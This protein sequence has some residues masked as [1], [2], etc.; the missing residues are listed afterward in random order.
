MNIHM[1]R[2]ILSVI[3]LV[4]LGQPSLLSAQ[5]DK[6]KTDWSVAIVEAT[7]KRLPTPKDMGV[8]N[9][10]R[11]LYLYS[12]YLVYKR[13]RD[14]RYL[15]Y[16]KDWV[17][18]HVDENGVITN[19]NPRGEK[20]E[21]RF[22]SLDNMMPGNLL[23]A[24]YQETKDN[25]YKL[26]AERIRIRFSGY[27]RTTD[28]GFWHAAYRTRESQLW[29][30]G[31]FMSMP[32]LIRYGSIFGDEK[33][34]DNEAAKQL[35]VY[36]SHLN[37]PKTGLMFH[38]YDE[39]GKATWTDKQTKHSPEIWCRAMGWF[40]MTIVEVLELIPKDHPSRPKLI[41]QLNQLIKA[42]SNFQ[43]KKTGLWYQVVDKGSD[44]ANWLE[45]SSSSMY[46]FTIARAV[47]RGYVDKSYLKVAKLGYAG[48]LT[49][50]SI[51][52]DGGPNLIDICE[53]TNVADLPY[54]FARKRLTNDLHGLGAFLIMNEKF[55]NHSLKGSTRSF[56][57]RG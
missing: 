20:V 24:M 3:L 23:L 17:D 25:R 36:A 28:G 2:F 40:G 4:L 5:T 39:S 49:K 45:T 29:G 38:A 22:D 53:G 43:D 55:M 16:I 19:I 42:W 48:V 12:Q 57:K 7:M 34:A 21:V 31:V 11:G 50:I 14:P 13:T 35:L 47:D 18:S 9:Y 10:P 6:T 52:P 56:W 54:Y 41:A 37:D 1:R 26:A 15:K 44:P 8:W 32:F 27:P 51:G 33:Y 46:T 30:D